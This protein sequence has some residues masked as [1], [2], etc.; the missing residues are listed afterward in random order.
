MT[1]IERSKKPPKLELKA[2]S[3]EED[4]TGSLR[5]PQEIATDIAYQC[6]SPAIPSFANNDAVQ[7]SKTIEAQ[8]RK[9]IAER[10]IKAGITTPQSPGFSRGTWRRAVRP[11]DI[12][13]TPHMK[14][15]PP[16]IYSAPLNIGTP[17]S[18]RDEQIVTISGDYGKRSIVHAKS[19]R[20]EYNAKWGMSDSS[21]CLVTQ[22]ACLP[23]EGSR[24]SVPGSASL[25]SKGPNY[26]YSSEKSIKIPQHDI[27]V[28]KE[29]VK[30]KNKEIQHDNSDDDDEED[31]G[32]D[33]EE[34]ALSDDEKEDN[35]H[36]KR[37]SYMISEEEFEMRSRE[38]LKRRR[39]LK[40][41]SLCE[42]MWD[43]LHEDL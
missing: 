18:G 30:F 22:E 35:T 1:S 34:A 11:P 2:S 28:A 36:K 43:L 7:M 10:N 6:V 26:A 25:E 40:F 24:H 32:R 15:H 9:L 23:K 21:D 41:M 29:P 13:I 3:S 31:D 42:D 39:K 38:E 12:L 17:M 20:A 14:A 37:Q 27:P 4:P 16:R 8:Q 33:P 19:A 5:T